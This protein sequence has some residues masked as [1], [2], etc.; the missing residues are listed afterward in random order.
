MGQRKQIIILISLVTLTVACGLPVVRQGF[1]LEDVFDQKFSNDIDNRLDK[2]Q[3]YFET[4]MYPE[5]QAILDELILEFPDEPRFKYL[6]AIVD[7]QM[8]NYGRAEKIFTEFIE[9]YP[10]VAEPYYILG[11][12]NLNTDNKDMAKQYLKKYC[13]LV[14][15]DYEA[16]DKLS[17]IFTEHTS[18]ALIMEYGREEPQLVKKVGFYGACLHSYEKQSVKLI[19]GS[20]RTWSS[21]GIDFVYPIDLRGKQITLQLKGKQGG[22]RLELTF[23]DKFAKSHNS[24]LVLVPE[25]RATRRWE[26]IKVAFGDQ[27]SGI[28]LSCIVHMGLEFGSSTVRNPANSTLYVNDIIIEDVCN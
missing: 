8:G 1:C 25:E 10:G 28:D 3:I 24:Q 16:Q 17:S 11:E 26:K 15:E 7:Y 23:R 18:R 6:R 27:H 9:Q 20:H 19:N 12:I 22:E 4:E 5:A 21:M 2:L 14:P 13:E